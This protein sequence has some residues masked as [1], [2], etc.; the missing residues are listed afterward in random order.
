MTISDKFISDCKRI[1][2]VERA[3]AG[4]KYDEQ[5]ASIATEKIISLFERTSPKYGELPQSIAAY[6]NDSYINTSATP[7]E[8]PTDAHIEK[9]AA[10]LSF[11]FSEDDDFAQI[12]QDDWIEIADCI[13]DEAGSLPIETLTQMMNVILERKAL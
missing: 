4:N 8:E 2:K 5:V 11:L 12:S 9:L 10:F 13:N 7:C 1:K 3:N 6:W